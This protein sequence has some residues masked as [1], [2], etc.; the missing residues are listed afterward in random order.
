MRTVPCLSIRTFV[1]A[2]LM[3]PAGHAM[4]AQTTDT[5]KTAAAADT[6][7]VRTFGGFVDTY[8][9][10][11]FN[12]PRNF[13]RAY[14]TQPARH[15]EANVNLAY[16]ET[17]W[18]GPRY[19]GRLAL[20]W[21][22]SVQANYAGEP[23][24]GGVSGP[25]VSQFIQEATAGYQLAPTVWLDAGVFFSHLG[26]EGWISRDNLS[27]TRSL[28]ADFSPYYEA[29]AKVTWAA[30][31]KLTATFVLINGWQDVSNYNTPPAGGVRL[32]YAPTKTVTLTY[33]NFI[34]NAAADSAPVRMRVYHDVVAQYNAN[35]RWQL[36]AAYA[37]GTESGR[38]P[39]GGTASWW[40]VTTFAKYHATPSLSFVGRVEQYSDPSQVI[41]VTGLP[42][43]FQTTAAS[44]GAD[45]K[46]QAPVL[47]RTELRGF[48]S[49]DAVWP[50]HAVGGLST[51]DAFFV[52]SLALTF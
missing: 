51:N 5:T 29:G 50:T 33:D 21:G 47:W 52:S 24:I 35:D 31:P 23:R 40:G 49:K 9:A 38:T 43:S 6:N 11:D 41:V 3:S 14:T 13:D 26:L 45:V 10:W 32:D 42:A 1:A 39:S 15:A 46:L 12:R 28:V 17:K 8:Y 27:Y 48:R 30:S 7:P 18:S 19:R 37:L 44:V 16:I 2:A 22:T 25:N 34:G 4:S 36:A 20:Q